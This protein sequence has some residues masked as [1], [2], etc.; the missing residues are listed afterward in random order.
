MTLITVL[1]EREKKKKALRLDAIN[2]AYRLAA[3]LKERFRFESLYIYGSI[4]SDHF[5]R[6]SDIDMIIKG[7]N[8]KDFFKAHA[9]LIKQSSYTVDLKPFEDLSADFREKVL[10][11]GIKIG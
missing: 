10:A 6:Q 5:S 3:L 2:E 9:F 11:G 1:K 4:L 7:L 8:V